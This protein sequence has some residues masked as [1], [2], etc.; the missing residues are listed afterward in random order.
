MKA[1]LKEAPP[2]TKSKGFMLA[3]P[4]IDEKAM[5]VASTGML[6]TLLDTRIV[7][8]RSYSVVADLFLK[9]KSF[10]KNVTGEFEKAKHSADVAHKSI[11]ALEKKAL[12]RFVEIEETCEKKMALYA[13]END[14]PVV[15]GVTP[16]D[17]YSY[18]IVDPA[19]VPR[20]F[21]S[22]DRAKIRAMVIASKEEA[23]KLIPGIKVIR[24]KRFAGTVAE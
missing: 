23:E 8:D 5:E 24:E 9:A 15:A 10:I 7:D 12:S 17:G 18:E 11:C 14:L 3:P 22:P 2:P 16:S 19:L 4:M 6:K 13:E 20:E 1:K 21:C